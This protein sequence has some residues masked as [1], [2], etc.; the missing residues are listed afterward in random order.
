VFLKEHKGAVFC[1]GKA[2]ARPG[3]ASRPSLRA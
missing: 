1:K 3:N 2:L